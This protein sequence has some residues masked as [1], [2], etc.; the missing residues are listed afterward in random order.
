MAAD[1]KNADAESYQQDTASAEAFPAGI[2][3]A[4]T[5]R[6]QTKKRGLSVRQSPFIHHRGFTTSCIRQRRPMAGGKWV[7]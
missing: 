7:M 4:A 5:G 1:K 2:R 3:N 6:A